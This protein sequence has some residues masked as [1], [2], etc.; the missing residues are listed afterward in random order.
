LNPAKR[1]LIVEDDPSIRQVLQDNLVFEGFVTEA[2]ADGDEAL[3]RAPLFTPDLVLLDLMLPT[4]EGF[5]VCSVLG[6]PPRR[7]PIIILTARNGKEDKIRG[8]ELGA[9]DYVTKPFALE[10]LLARIHAVLRRTQPASQERVTIGD[11]VLDFRR[12][13]AWRGKVEVALTAKEFEL[14]QCLV[15]RAGRAVS[16]DELLRLVWHYREIPMTRTVDNF[17]ARLR[18]KLETDP[19]QARLIRTVHGDGYALCL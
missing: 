19:H 8:L 4:C 18:R 10:E 5:K 12:M 14:L 2:V 15:D 13:R 16:R 9:D 6:A 7:T 3:K 17:I 11:V 1:I